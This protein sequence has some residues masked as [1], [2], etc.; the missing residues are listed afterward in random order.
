MKSRIRRRIA[1]AAAASALGLAV[2]ASASAQ[3]RTVNV[4]A[5]SGTFTGSRQYAYYGYVKVQVVL[6]SGAVSGIRIMEYP[7]DNGRSH[8]INSVAL[9]YLVQETVGGSTWKVDLVSGA[10][11]TS[12]AYV[13]SLQAA[14]KQ[15]GL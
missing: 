5:A 9:P 2:S 13:K 14:L 4:S 3:A 11:F 15:A 8:Y 10:T 12:M 1:A 7:N 6:A